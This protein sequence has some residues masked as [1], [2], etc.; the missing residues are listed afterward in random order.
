MLFPAPLG[1]VSGQ[2]STFLKSDLDRVLNILL[3]KRDQE[4][5]R[6]P[7]DDRPPL[8]ACERLTDLNLGQPRIAGLQVGN[9]GTEP[10]ASFWLIRYGLPRLVVMEDAVKVNEVAWLVP[11]TERV[12]L[13][14][15][16]V[17][18]R[19]HLHPFSRRKGG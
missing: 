6:K 14:R 10:S 4:A 7:G 2:A 13:A 3:F 17:S 12:K 19:G 16:D 18:I 8:A 5:K 1:P 9:E 11:V 15:A